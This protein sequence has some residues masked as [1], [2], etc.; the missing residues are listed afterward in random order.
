MKVCDT[1]MPS[2][3][4]RYFATVLKESPIV[5]LDEP[6]AVIADRVVAHR[7]ATIRSADQIL[8]VE[9][10]R[11]EQRGRHDE[12]LG[13]GGLLRATVDR[14]RTGGTLAR[15]TQRGLRAVPVRRIDRTRFVPA[16]TRWE[17]RHLS[18]HAVARRAG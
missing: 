11:V 4:L 18:A 6:T 12:L 16:V 8:A 13:A 1:E 5:L 15:L 9:A 10:G 2:A 3:R 7:L 14:T 17:D